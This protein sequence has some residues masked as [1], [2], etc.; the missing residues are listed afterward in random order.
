MTRIL[1]IDDDEAIR[2]SLALLLQLRGFEV[3]TASNG[4]D[5]VAIFDAQRPT[6]VITDMMMPGGEGRDVIPQI[7]RIAPDARI[8]AMSGSSSSGE[9]GLLDRAAE[10]GADACLRKPFEPG[11]LF[12]ALGRE[13]G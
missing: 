5:G 3:L 10:L 1:V 13:R 12:V 8:I 2:E 11:E 6:I 4:L 9:G 7:R